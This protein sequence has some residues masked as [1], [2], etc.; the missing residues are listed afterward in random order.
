MFQIND[1]NYLNFKEKN[2]LY[3]V[4]YIKG[5]CYGC[6]Q[7]DC[8]GCVY[9]DEKVVI[10]FFEGNVYCVKNLFYQ[11]EYCEKNKIVYEGFFVVD[12]FQSCQEMFDGVYEYIGKV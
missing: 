12:E 1:L 2:Y 11:G 7:C 10:V 4:K 6:E 8:C 9:F 5:Y 3:G